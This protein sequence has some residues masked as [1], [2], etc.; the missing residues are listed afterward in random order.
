[1]SKYNPNY[2][3]AP[4]YEAAQKWRDTALTA[5]QS[6]L[7]D[8]KKLW[9]LPL[10]DELDQRY[11]QN[12][13]PSKGNFLPKLKEQLAEGSDSCHQLMAEILWLLYL[14]P[15]PSIMRAATKRKSV[16]EI[17]SWSG[18]KLDPTHPLL[19]DAVLGGIGL[20]GPEYNRQRWRELVLFINALRDFKAR[21]ASEQ[22]RIASDPWEFSGWFSG[23]PGHG[24]DSS[25]TSFRT[26][27]FPTR[28]S[29]SVPGVTSA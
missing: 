4:I 12:L 21:D 13:V 29:V 7:A 18:E 19:E 1:M 14:F 8:G 11:V 15:F 17:W 9:T 23:F 20:T 25:S 22:E 2:H 10:L 3:V 6:V 26:C 27:C 24:K 16:M 5:E 28:S